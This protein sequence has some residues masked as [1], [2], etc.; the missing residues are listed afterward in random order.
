MWVI[1][2]AY[3]TAPT[4]SCTL[5]RYWCDSPSFFLPLQVQCHTLTGYCWCVTSDGK[6]VS[7][8]SV[9]N[10]TPVCSGTGGRGGKTS[11][12]ACGQN[13]FFVRIS[14]AAQLAS[15]L[16]RLLV[17][18]VTSTVTSNR[19]C[20]L[21]SRGMVGCSLL[22]WR[23]SITGIEILSMVYVRSRQPGVSGSKATEV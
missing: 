18:S 12:S 1:W 9:H 10:R 21:K 6:P 13:V 16:H 4:A 19:L 8:S 2:S 5:R 14:L 17:I 23:G 7:G 22:G 20:D 15:V 3:L 11:P